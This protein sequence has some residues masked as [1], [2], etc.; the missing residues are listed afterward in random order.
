VSETDLTRYRQGQFSNF[1][2]R[3]YLIGITPKISHFPFS[4]SLLA[5]GKTF[6]L[7]LFLSI[8]SLFS[9]YPTMLSNLLPHGLNIIVSFSFSLKNNNKLWIDISIS[10]QRDSFGIRVLVGKL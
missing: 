4:F 7:P 2:R 10:S 6:L 1:P 8:G 3:G 9:P 5:F